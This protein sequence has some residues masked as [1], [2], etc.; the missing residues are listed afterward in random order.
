MKKIDIDYFSYKRWTL[1]KAK[2]KLGWKLILRLNNISVKAI[3]ENQKL[4]LI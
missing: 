3:N 2:G 4:V 1:G